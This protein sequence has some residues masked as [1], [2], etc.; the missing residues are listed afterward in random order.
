MG[1]SGSTAYRD[2]YEN[3]PHKRQ[4]MSVD[5]ARRPAYD[6]EQQLAQRSA[7]YRDS[8][9]QY[10]PREYGSTNRG[11]YFSQ[12][13]PSAPGS[14]VADLTFGHQRTNSSSTSSSFI[15]PRNDYPYLPNALY[16]QPMRDPSYQLSF[17]DQYYQHAGS[18][19]TGAPSRQVPQLAQPV[20]TYRTAASSIPS[21]SEQLR[22]YPRP[23]EGDENPS[24]ERLYGIT[25]PTSRPDYFSS[26]HSSTGYDRPLQ[27][28]ARTLP[29]PSQSST[30]V[31]PP[32]Q[33]NGTSSQTRTDPV[34]NYS[35]GDGSTL[36]GQS[37]IPSSMA[38]NQENQGYMPQWY[39]GQPNG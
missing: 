21:Q 5:L 36:E 9:N 10:F 3:P 15:S 27:S 7:Q 16:Q 4:K 23:Y 32:L 26:Q 13:T 34:Q 2:P 30:S 25:Q 22:S 12:P 33:S 37:Q 11:L 20:P 17:R 29:D 35:N 39:R 14:A 1:V 6:Q 8:F 31:L 28:L 18:Q 38:T 19:F 24:S